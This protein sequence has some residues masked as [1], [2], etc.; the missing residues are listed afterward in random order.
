M[1]KKYSVTYKVAKSGAE[2]VY[3]QDKAKHKAGDL[4]ISPGGHM[5][6]ALNDGSGSSES[7]GFES[8]NDEMFGPGQVTRLDN[9][10]Y[11][12]TE[13]EVNIMLTEDQYNKLQIFSR[14]PVSNGFDS[15]MYNLLANSCVDFV[16]ASLQSIGYNNKKFEGDLFPKDSIKPLHDLLYTHGAQIV[17]DD[18][19]RK[20]D[21]YDVK[22]GQ[23]CLWLGADEVKPA[24]QTSNLI[25]IDINPS[26]QPQQH[27]QGESKAQQ[28]VANGFIQ[29]SATHNIFAVGGILNKTD[30]TST[31]MAS[32]AS[33]GIRPG[34]MQLD[35][36]VRPN[37]Y[38]TQFY[39]PASPEKPDF[40]LRNTMTMN[41]LSA[42]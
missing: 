1:E 9:A 19:T 6:Y 31:Q 35:S 37:T 29:N 42:M 21:Y 24:S 8:K 15:S 10:G 27:I 41:G 20:G 28:D 2:Y 40:S 12:D 26:S 39:Q 38:L 34:E 14:N 36:N 11:R 23:V 3:Q 25:N 4:H 16:F 7:Y 32:L 22:N 13:Y 30:F 18:L 5:W 33:G 17:R